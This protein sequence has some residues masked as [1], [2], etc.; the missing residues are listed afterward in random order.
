MTVGML[1]RYAADSGILL[2][3]CAPEQDDRLLEVL[4]QREQDGIKA[5]FVHWSAQQRIAPSQV[6]AGVKSIISIALPHVDTV[7]NPG[8]VKRGKIARFAR[9]EDY[10]VLVKEKLQQLALICQQA[11]GATA[12]AFHVD[13]GPLVDRYW[14]VK[15]GL[16]V[17][18]KNTTVIT[19]DAGS[20]V[21][22]GQLLLDVSLPK[23]GN[24]HP[25][26]QQN[27]EGCDRCIRS[28][29]TG[30]IEEAYVVNPYKCLSYLTKAKGIFPKEYR[31]QLGDRLYGCDICQEA[32]PGNRRMLQQLNQEQCS[33]QQLEGA[34]PNLGNLLNLTN[35]QF[36]ALYGTSAMGWCGKNVIQRNALIACGNKGYLPPAVYQATESESAMLR[37]HAY[38][39]IAKNRDKGAKTFLDS[40]RNTE[41]D[42]EA[43]DELKWCLDYCYN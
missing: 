28:C 31:E 35:K 30:A 38:W 15:S 12:V 22:L 29:P 1:E 40:K 26:Q 10:H 27:C 11:L 8:D 13:T 36:K 18:G 24:A 16:A 43:A 21:T 2:G 17:Y 42:P 37:A 4:V 6:L 7:P 41:S 25:F 32:C 33:E 14:A 20:W 3:W 19:Q 34:F 9:G 23:G 5:P 39:A